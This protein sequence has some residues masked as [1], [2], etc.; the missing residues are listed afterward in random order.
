LS[1]KNNTLYAILGMIAQ[2]P[3][4][5]Y[6]IRKPF[7]ESLSFFWSESY[8]QIYPALKEIVKEGYAEEQVEPN[9]PRKKKLYRISAKGLE[10]FREWLSRPVDP[11]NYRDELLLK[12]FLASPQDH[13][14]ILSQIEREREELTSN[15]AKLREQEAQARRHYAGRTLPPWILT[16]RYGILS[17]EARLNWCEE[18]VLYLKELEKGSD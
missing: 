11:I 3:R 5:G 7:N 15:L 17:M 1:R 10:I 2:G 18:S 14:A 9:D 12:I 16:L 8:G 4:S 13:R 6:D